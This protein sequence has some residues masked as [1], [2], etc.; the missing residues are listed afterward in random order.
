MWSSL[1]RRSVVVG[2][3][4]FSDLSKELAERADE[5]FASLTAAHREI[6]NDIDVRRKR[7]IYRSKQRGWLEVDLLLGI[8]ATKYVPT[9]TVPECDDYEAILNLETI[10]IFNLITNKDT[11]PPELDTPMMKRLQTYCTL[12]PLGVTTDAY[13]RAKSLHN[14]T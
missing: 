14:L 10:D 5:R 2:R 11:V 6:P 1:A 9:F 3:R 4:N 13:V 7:L 8:F 12:N